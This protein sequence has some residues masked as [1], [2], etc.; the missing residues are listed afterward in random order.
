VATRYSWAVGW[1]WIVDQVPPPLNVIVAPPSFP[2]I[3]RRE[4]SG[5]IQRSWLSP[6][7]ARTVVY[8]LPPSTDL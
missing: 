3:M 1:F 5:S 8:V 4:S 6:C 2:L 7:G